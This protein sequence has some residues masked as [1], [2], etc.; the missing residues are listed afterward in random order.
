MSISVNL[1]PKAFT[2]DHGASGTVWINVDCEGGSYATIHVTADQC[3][4]LIAAATEAKRLLT[5]P[6]EGGQS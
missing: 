1:H 6:P 3:D 5:A 2:A 4:K